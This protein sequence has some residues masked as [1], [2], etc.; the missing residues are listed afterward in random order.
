MALI[1]EFEV[2]VDRPDEVDEELRIVVAVPEFVLVELTVGESVD[3]CEP[4][5]VAE[6]VELTVK[7]A[8]TEA[9][10]V[11]ELVE[12]GDALRTAVLEL[13]PL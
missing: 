2:A 13:V 4:L 9:V 6:D 7:L 11:A 5:S 10:V 3:D 8:D 1:E 12:V